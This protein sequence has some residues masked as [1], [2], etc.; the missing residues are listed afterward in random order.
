MNRS[1][2]RSHRILCTVLAPA[3]VALIAYALMTRDD[4]HARLAIVPQ[5]SEP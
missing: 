5:E 2:R 3:L 4:P 1:Q